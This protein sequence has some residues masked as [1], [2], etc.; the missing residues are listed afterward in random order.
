MRPWYPRRLK[1]SFRVFQINSM[2]MINISHKEFTLQ[3]VPEELFLQ[4]CK[5]IGYSYETISRQIHSKITDIIDKGLAA[6]QSDFIIRTTPIT[7][8]GNGRIDTETVTID[9]KKWA[10]LLRKME[11][12]EFICCF[13]V[14][15]G[16]RIDVIK[17]GFGEKNLFDQFVLDAL[18][19]VLVEKAADSLES[20]IGIEFKK[21]SYECSRRFSPGYCDWELK[22]GQATLCRFLSPEKIGVQCMASGAMIPIK[23][24]SAVMV[25]AMRVPWKVPCYFC[26]EIR[27]PYRR[28]NKR[29]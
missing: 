5:Q 1:E 14:T 16:K 23:S 3:E 12:P 27:C 2:Q 18:G 25:G 9:S 21:N 11:S 8:W 22:S 28:E 6:M 7:G 20:S 26:R 13:I 4:V 19:S 10:S 29:T 24:V 17:E 15:L